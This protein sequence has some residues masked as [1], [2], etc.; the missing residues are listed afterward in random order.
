MTKPQV[1][2]LIVSDM[3]FM[4]L[5]VALGHFYNWPLISTQ[6][7]SASVIIAYWSDT[8]EHNF[9]LSYEWI[10]IQLCVHYLKVHCFP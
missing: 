6:M 9:L 4:D 10:L 8:L 5:D 1:T 7:L 3:D 2:W